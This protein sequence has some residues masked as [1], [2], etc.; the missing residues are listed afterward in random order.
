MKDYL[1]LM[2]ILL[3]G[4]VALSAAEK[5][6]FIIFI[7]DDVSWDDFGCYGNPDVHTPNIDRIA[8][9]GV[10]FEKAFLT[11]SSCSPSRNSILTGRYPHNTGAAEL[12]T[13]PPLDMPSLAGLLQANGYYTALAGKFHLGEY[14]MEAFDTVHKDKKL[15]GDGGEAQWLQ[16]LEERASDQPFFFWF[17]SRDGHRPWGPNEFAGTHDPEAIEVPDYLVD[18]Y[19]TRED[20]AHYYDEVTRFD[21]YIGEVI[22]QLEAASLLD[23]TWIF[24]LADNGRAFPASKTRI[25]DR[26]VRTP[27]VVHAPTVETPFVYEHLVSV[28]DLAP[29]ISELAGL[30]PLEGFQGVSLLPALQDPAVRLRDY[31]FAEHNWHDYEAFERMV[32]SQDFLY[33][34]NGRPNKPQLGDAGTVGSPSFYDLLQVKARRSLTMVQADIFVTPRAQEE[35]YDLK[36]DPAQWHNRASD[37]QYEEALT[38]LRTELGSWTEMTG[39]TEPSHLTQD[40]FLPIPGYIKTAEYRIRGEMPGAEGAALS[41][42]GQPGVVDA[43]KR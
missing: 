29:T 38:A 18:A 42:T 22:E 41:A 21:H 32:R 23:D 2:V 11:T 7:A 24:V 26:G 14:A 28:I 9:E 13:E 15:M 16:T 6:N 37:P 12:H 25:N 31:V 17:A 1:R 36:L 33:L 30:E 39:D 40:Y 35:L 10:L 4:T 43:F 8:E 34:Y 5:P 27:L 19:R 3:T 20:L